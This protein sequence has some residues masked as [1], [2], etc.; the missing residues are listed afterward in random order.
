MEAIK[1][2]FDFILGVVEFIMPAIKFVVEMVWEA[3]KNIISGALDVIMGAV[4][5]FSGLFTGDF[6]KMWEG[7]KQL[8]GG[9][10]D[11]IVGITSLSFFGGIRTL[12]LNFTKGLVGSMRTMWDDIFK[13]F[14]DMGS[15][16]KSVTDDFLTAAVNLFKN[17]KESVKGKMTEVKDLIIKIWNTVMDFFKSI[18]LSQIGK[19]IIQGLINGIG[20][21]ASAVWNKAKEIAN[22]IASSISGALGIHSPSKVT[23]QFGVWIG[24]GL[25][26]GIEESKS[27]VEQAVDTLSDVVN[28]FMNDVATDAKLSLTPSMSA[29]TTPSSSRGVVGT[30]AVDESHGNQRGGFTQNLTINAPTELDPSE[31]ARMNRQA[32]QMFALEVGLR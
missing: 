8:F 28:G 24:E 29:Y 18:D 32:S 22:G 7:I 26:I 10:I 4:K 12:A 1:N 5:V 20:S 30:V 16:V 19:N 31:T 17:F 21:M 3:I 11:L 6:S 13:V 2:A 14:K 27:D 9:F 23:T 15:S 25:A